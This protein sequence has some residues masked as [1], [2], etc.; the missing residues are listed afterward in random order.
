M[1]LSGRIVFNIYH[2]PWPLKTE[3]RFH[4]HSKKNSSHPHVP[5][6]LRHKGDSKHISTVQNSQ[7]NGNFYPAELNYQNKLQNLQSTYSQLSCRNTLPPE[8]ELE[9]FLRECLNVAQS[10]SLDISISESSKAETESTLRT[11]NHSKPKKKV[12]QTSP[13]VEHII[14]SVSELAFSIIKHKNVFISPKLLKLYIAVQAAL[15]SPDTFPEIFYLYSHKPVPLRNTSPIRYS[16]PNPNLFTNSIPQDIAKVALEAAI[17]AKKLVVAIDIIEAA[18]TSKAFKSSK[19]VRQALLPISLFSMTPFAIYT[20]A[21]QLSNWQ[22]SMDAYTSRN[23]AF[24]GMMAYLG[25]T[26]TVGFIAISTSN[27]HMNRVTWAPGVPLRQRWIREDERAAID[28]VASAW[29]FRESWRRGDEEGEEWDLI[30]EWVSRRSM[31]LDRV[32]L[33]EGMN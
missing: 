9:I 6:F 13:E 16:K 22:T 33:M 1:N 19:F 14:Q 28:K 27:D 24:L 3:R 30:K 32:E 21:S 4:L 20:L 10:L 26:G 23:V 18:Y 5:Y 11:L 15:G 8:A 7:N 17:K 2:Q 12:C 25:L 29:G 31:I